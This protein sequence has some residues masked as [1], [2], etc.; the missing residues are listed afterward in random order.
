MFG[1]QVCKT[2]LGVLDLSL[3]GKML[4][5]FGNKTELPYITFP[6]N[7]AMDISSSSINGTGNSPAIVATSASATSSAADTTWESSRHYKMEFSTE[8][9]DLATWKTVAPFEF[10]LQKVWGEG[11]PLQL[12]IFHQEDD[13]DKKRTYLLQLQ[14]TPQ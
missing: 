5:S 9:V 4:Y 7:T 11:T 10:P 6:L 1:K 14:L 12:I 13:D 8:N 2:I 3:P